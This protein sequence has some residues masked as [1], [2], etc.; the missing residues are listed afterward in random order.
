M[1]AKLHATR[2][3]VAHALDPRHQLISRRTLV[4]D[5]LR[6]VMLKVLE[7]DAPSP[8]VCDRNTAGGCPEG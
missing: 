6:E 1:I 2:L 3:T 8:I 4:A 5:A 7:H